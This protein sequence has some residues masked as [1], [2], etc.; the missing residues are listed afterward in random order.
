MR[1]YTAPGEVGRLLRRE[2]LYRLASDGLAQGVMA[3]PGLSGAMELAS[4]KKRGAKPADSST[5]WMRRMAR[6]RAA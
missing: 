3:T 5:R 1:C 4:V 6:A 2:G